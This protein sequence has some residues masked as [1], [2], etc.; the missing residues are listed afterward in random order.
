M[1][2]LEHIQKLAILHCVFQT[3]ASAD[4]CINEERD[5]KA[6]SLALEFVGSDSI[7]MWDSA[8]KLDP[9]DC[10]YHISVLSAEDKDAFKELIS[11]IV[12]MG[13]D[14]GLRKICADHLLVLCQI[15][16]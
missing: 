4:G 2:H 9:H 6:I 14:A 3:I 11:K 1:K 13:G 7:Y 5:F 12:N 15:E 10:F 8:L 16:N